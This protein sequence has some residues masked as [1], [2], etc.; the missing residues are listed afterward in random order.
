MNPNPHQLA[1][2]P[3][4]L[5]PHPNRPETWP[6]FRPLIIA[7]DVG[8]VRDHSTAVVGGASPY[9][10]N[11]IGLRDFEELPQGL[12]GSGRASAL[13]EIDRR[14]NSNAL[15]V[16]DLSNEASYGEFLHQTFG[17]RVIGLQIGRHGSGSTFEWRPVGPGAM[18]VYNVGRTFLLEHFHSLMAN[19]MVRIAK[20]PMAERAFAQLADLQTEMREGSTVYSTLPGQHDDLAISCC[21]LAFAARHPHLHSWMRHASAERMPPPPQPKFNFRDACC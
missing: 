2:A 6:I 11:I 19:K 12:Y 16:A 14:Y 9:H 5:V 1:P 4:R 20:G 7:H 10:Q 18:L 8:R 15:I 13:A 21:M 17:H 3:D